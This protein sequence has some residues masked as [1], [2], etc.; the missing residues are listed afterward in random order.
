LKIVTLILLIDTFVYEKISRSHIP[1]SNALS[2][3]LPKK[4]ELLSAQ[5]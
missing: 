3:E 5:C 2:L 1:V 4:V